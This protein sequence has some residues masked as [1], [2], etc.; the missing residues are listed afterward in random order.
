MKLKFNS[1]VPVVKNLFI[2]FDFFYMFIS[3]VI[4]YIYSSFKYV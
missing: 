3:I 1:L 4:K 2:H